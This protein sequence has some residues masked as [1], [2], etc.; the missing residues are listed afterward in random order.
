VGIYINGILQLANETYVG[1][2]WRAIAERSS[3]I[4]VFFWTELDYLF[5]ILTIGVQKRR[6]L[7]IFIWSWTETFLW[8]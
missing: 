2:M 1:I 7:T 6:F 5:N 8:C 4:F 3:V